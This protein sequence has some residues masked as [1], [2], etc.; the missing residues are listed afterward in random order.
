MKNREKYAE[1]ILDIAC[2]GYGVGINKKTGK[3]CRC[4]EEN[5]TEC[6]FDGRTNNC[7]I[8]VNEWANSQYIEKPKLTKNEKIFL[9][10]LDKDWVY[11]TEDHVG[12]LRV[13]KAKPIKGKDW[14]VQKEEFSDKNISGLVTLN[15]KMVSWWDKEPWLIEDLKNLEV[16]EEYETN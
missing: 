11:M 3:P 1:Q 15:F 5:C 14:W 8:E 12:S 13:H 7:R 16:E 10:C 9:D 6:A 4:E 2:D